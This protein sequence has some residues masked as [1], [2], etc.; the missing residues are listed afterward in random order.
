MQQAA[1]SRN[2]L[3][4]YPHKSHRLLFGDSVIYV[5]D[6]EEIFKEINNIS[7]TRIKDISKTIEEIA[8]NKLDYVSISEKILIDTQTH[9]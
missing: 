1:C 8:R 7:F 6:E 9:K 2:A 4:L 3:I 5:K